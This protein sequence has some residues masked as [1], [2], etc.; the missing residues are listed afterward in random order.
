MSRNNFPIDRK[1]LFVG[2]LSNGVQEEGLRTI[3]EKYGAVKSV[4]MKDKG[5]TNIFAFV[6]FDDSN[7]ADEAINK[8]NDFEIEG[9]KIRI[10]YGRGGK[11]DRGFGNSFGE[12]KRCFNCQSLNHLARDCPEANT[13]DRGY[14]SDRRERSR[15]HDRRD[16]RH[17]GSRGRKHSDSY[18]RRDKHRDRREDHR[19]ERREDRR[20]DRREDRGDD[21]GGRGH[22][23]RHREERRD[24]RRR[25]DHREERDR[26]EFREGGRRGSEERRRH[27]SPPRH[28]RGAEHY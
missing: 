25:D 10:E 21:R 23:D 11:P 28:S 1:K 27:S 6:E 19:D 20:S 7:E 4:K 15:S 9:N 2:N 22:G 3:F 26:R 18:E 13:R 24:D 16:R 14:R 5:G 8:L 12:P 17:S